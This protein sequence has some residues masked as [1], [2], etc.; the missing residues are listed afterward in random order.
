MVACRVEGG[1]WLRSSHRPQRPR[2]R[3]QWQ[4]RS[5]SKLSGSHNQRRRWF[6]NQRKAP[7]TFWGLWLKNNRRQERTGCWG[8][9]TWECGVGS[10]AQW[11]QRGPGFQP[12][13]LRRWGRRG[14]RRW[15]E[16]EGHRWGP[17]RRI[18]WT[19]WCCLLSLS[20]SAG[21]IYRMI[22]RCVQLRFLETC[23]VWS[24]LPSQ[25]VLWVSTVTFIS[26]WLTYLLL[27]SSLF[28]TVFKGMRKKYGVGRA[29]VNLS[30]C[31]SWS[32]WP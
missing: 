19:D 9:N 21:G 6:G 12:P 31:P 22:V 15:A 26:S 29:G 8:R 28:Y 32:L 17:R 14:Q 30:F 3:T 11:K 4:Q 25:D 27:P 7:S 18:H 10:T 5:R 20:S 23:R 1:R 13:W 16:A 2:G 24:C